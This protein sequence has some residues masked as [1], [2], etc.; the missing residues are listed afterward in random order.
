MAEA[1][2]FVHERYLP[3]HH[4][5]VAVEPANP[6]DA[7]R[8]LLSTHDLDAIGSV[9][10]TRTG[11]R[12]GAVRMQNRVFPLGPD[13]PVRSRSKDPLVIAPRVDGTVHLRSQGRDLAFTPIATPAPRPCHVAARAPLILRQPRP[14]SRPPRTHPWKDPSYY[15]MRRRQAATNGHGMNTGLQDAR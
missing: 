7:P 5:R 9:Q 10:T 12:D 13:Q 3:R 14:P 15:A 4:A 2:R 1:H 6:T 11:E 8:P